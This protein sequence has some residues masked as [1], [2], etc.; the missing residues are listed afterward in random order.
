[1][2][3]SR[4]TLKS[5]VVLKIFPWKVSRLNVWKLRCSSCAWM[6]YCV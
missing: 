2:H 1:M 3:A 4:F 5:F 6:E